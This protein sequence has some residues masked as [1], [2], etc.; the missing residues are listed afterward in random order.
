M[1]DTV[2]Q[3]SEKSA[4]SHLMKVLG[5]VHIWALGVG[6]VLVGEFMGW[7]FTVAKGGTFGSLIACWV[8]GLLFISLVMINTEMGSVIPKAD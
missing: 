7:N 4:S 1:S 6:I 3:S 5:P 2:V 8:V